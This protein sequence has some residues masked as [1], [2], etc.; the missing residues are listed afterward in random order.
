MTVC[1]ANSL[2]VQKYSGDRCGTIRCNV[3][4]TIEYDDNGTQN[5]CKHQDFVV[6][7][8]KLNRIPKWATCI[9]LDNK[10]S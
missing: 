1:V 9:A 6:E 4:R 2:Q 5:G 3:H 7:R 8:L 10:F